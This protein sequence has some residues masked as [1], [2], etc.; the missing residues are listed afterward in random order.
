[1]KKFLPLLI[2]AILLVLMIGIIPVSA[3]ASISG[4]STVVAGRSYT[5]KGTAKYSAGDIICKIEGLGQVASGFANT[6]V[7][8][9]KS[10]TATASIKVTIPSNAKPGDTFAIKFSGQYSDMN[11]DGSGNSTAKSFTT[12]KTITVGVPSTPD[13]NATPKPLEGW[14]IVEDTIEQ[15]QEGAVVETVMTG[16][17]KIPKELLSKIIDNKNKLILD[18][19]TYKCT[20]DPAMLTDI[21]D[22][23]S[24]DLELDFE[25]AEELSE[26]AGGLDIYQLHFKHNG[27]LPGMLQFTFEAT[28]N[29]PGD[30]VYLYYYYGDANVIEGKVSAVVDENGMLTF[31]IYHCSS[32][33]VTSQIL[34]DAISNF[35]SN[36]AQELEAMSA[37]F[38]EAQETIEQMQIS[39]DDSEVQ[40][41][42]LSDELAKAKA[43]LSADDHEGTT[44]TS[45]KVEHV[46]VS[47][48]VLLVSLFGGILLSTSLTMLFFKVG[49]FKRA[50]KTT[51]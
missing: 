5:Y 12:T 2:V 27:E 24:L 36:S 21:K 46:S 17:Y 39:L 8:T 19:G 44:E 23:K 48:V 29:A 49:L 10:L 22:L 3:G 41:T 13:P 4:N 28:G 32:Y 20:I 7:M 47:L 43:E 11:P 1:M 51:N 34:P 33:F 45:A 40:I 38:N 6:T 37:L 15:A 30:V 14:E 16:D 18:F 42:K 26:A 9:N 25:K 50:Q 31:E 35:D